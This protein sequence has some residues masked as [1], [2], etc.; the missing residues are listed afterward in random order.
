LYLHQIIY[1]TNLCDTTC[2]VVNIM[3]A[4]LR[5]RSFNGLLNCLV[6]AETELL[7]ADFYRLKK[8]ST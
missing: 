7:P 6:V 5:N 4:S 2:V 8:Q 1:I 3:Q